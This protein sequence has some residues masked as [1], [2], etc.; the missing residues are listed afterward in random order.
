MADFEL[1][2]VRIFVTV[3]EEL[4]FRRAA[5]RLFL[6]QSVVSEQVKRL[7]HA[8]GVELFDRSRRNIVLTAAGMSLLPLARTLLDDAATLSSAA[9][10]Y[11]STRVLRLGIGCGMGRRVPLVFKDL[12]RKGYTV[13]AVEVAP[14]QRA[15]SLADGTIDAAFFRG[16]VRDMTLRSERVWEDRL[17][18]AMPEHHPLAGK[19]SVSIQELAESPVALASYDVNPALHDVLNEAYSTQGL[20]L[21]VGMPFTSVEATFAV[22]AANSAPMWT[23]IYETYEAEHQ[24]EGIRVVSIEP[25]ITIPTFFVAAPTMQKHWYSDLISTCETVA[26]SCAE[27]ISA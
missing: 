21:T 14:E 8:L 24:Y 23:P 25:A 6:P 19:D 27:P 17:I 4:H 3:A 1:R 26:M 11:R 9:N 13:R 18:A 22:M 20:R 15:A 5:D 2:Q 12:A 7:E 10:E 16:R